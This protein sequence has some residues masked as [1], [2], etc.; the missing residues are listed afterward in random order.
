MGPAFT[1]PN[2]QNDLASILTEIVDTRHRDSGSASAFFHLNNP[3]RVP[4]A[5]LIPAIQEMY[6]VEP[7][8]FRTWVAELESI[9][10]PTS[11]EVAEKPA[12]KL[13][14]FYRGLT[15]STA[16]M[17]IGLDV[18]RAQGA[19]ATMRSLGP[20]SGSLMRNWLRQWDF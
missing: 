15:E 7:V 3:E 13:L 1:D 5:S 16:A 9:Q 18:H 2:G 14:G 4:W 12:L 19:S 11:G 6:T 8:P 17:S 10:H 20:I